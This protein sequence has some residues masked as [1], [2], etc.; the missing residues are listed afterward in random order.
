MRISKRMKDTKN[1]ADAAVP[2]SE[3]MRRLSEEEKQALE[4]QEQAEH[5]TT[6]ERERLQRAAKEKAR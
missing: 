6:A 3:A 1:T 2:H 5:E 4:L